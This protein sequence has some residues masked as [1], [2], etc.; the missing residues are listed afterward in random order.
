MQSLQVTTEGSTAILAT[1]ASREV[2]IQAAVEQYR[3][4]LISGAAVPF[5]YEAEV[6]A[7]L[8]LLDT[9]H[10]HKLI[11]GGSGVMI[12]TPHPSSD[13]GATLLSGPLTPSSD[14]MGKA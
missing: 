10:G 13:I 9:N 14:T 1:E 3:K 11:R 5:E 2:A 6:R 7:M 4:A 8:K 12:G